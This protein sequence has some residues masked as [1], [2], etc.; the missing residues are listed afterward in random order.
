[1]I[2]VFLEEGRVRRCGRV[3]VIW[4]FSVHGCA[5]VIDVLRDARQMSCVLINE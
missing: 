5:V 4:L 3:D 2:K 1:M